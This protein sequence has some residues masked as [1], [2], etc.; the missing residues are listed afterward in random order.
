VALIENTDSISRDMALRLVGCA[1]GTEQLH[2]TLTPPPG[3]PTEWWP[4]PLTLHATVF[5]KDALPNIVSVEFTLSLNGPTTVPVEL[6]R[7]PGGPWG[8][9]Y[10]VIVYCNNRFSGSSEIEL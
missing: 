6:Q 10:F 8:S 2:L 9:K 3:T 7:Q 1:P 4:K 5:N